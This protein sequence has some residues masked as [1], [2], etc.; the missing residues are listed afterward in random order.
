MASTQVFRPARR[1]GERPAPTPNFQASTTRMNITFT[2]YGGLTRRCQ[3]AP[4]TL[5]LPDGTATLGDA[6]A[7]LGNRFPDAWE[8][9]ERAAL[10]VDD[11]IVSRR[12]V[13]E[14][15]MTV[16]LLPPVAGG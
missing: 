8:A 16:A 12:T 15:G 3:D 10:A 7:E 4:L 5:T 13:A 9:L 14:D 2:F 6:V 11:Q 1:R